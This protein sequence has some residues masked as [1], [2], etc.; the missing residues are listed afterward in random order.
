MIIERITV[1]ET[2]SS[3]SPLTVAVANI[4]VPI[5]NIEASYHPHRQPVLTHER[6]SQL[7]E[8]LNLAEKEDCDLLVLPEVSIPYSWFPFMVN[9]ARR[10]QTGLVFGIEHWVD[11]QGQVYNI[12]ATVLPYMVDGIYRSCHI[13]I[14][15]KNC[16]S[17]QENKELTDLGLSPVSPHDPT[18]KLYRWRGCDFSVFNCFELTDL[19]H[20]SAFRSEIDLLIAVEWNRDIPYFS[21]IVEST[22]RDL[23]CYMMQVNTSDYGD[24]R[25][26]APKD[27][28]HRDLVR[29]SGGLNTTLLKTDLDIAGLRDFQIREYCPTRT[30]F[31]PA[32]AGFD[33]QRVTAR[34]RGL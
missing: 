26:S 30:Q 18:Y 17:P 24:S 25:V 22:V 27:T 3:P 15:P 31:K 29:V 20:R 28:A 7:F 21:N 1:G 11:R 5:D 32:P 13:D 23:H 10:S 12:L 19:F 6:Q 2:P 9:H 4:H 33:R 8:L 34:N 16:H 14:R